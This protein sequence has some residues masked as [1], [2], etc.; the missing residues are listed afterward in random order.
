MDRLPAAARPKRAAEEFTRAQES[1]SKKP[2][3]DARNP[4]TLAADTNEED[5]ILNADVIG[6]SGLQTKRNAVNIDG[7]ESDSDNDNFNA[8]A[9]ERE[10]LSRRQK[11]GAKAVSKDEDDDDMFAEAE[12]AVQGTADGDDD[13]ELGREGKRVNK[14]VRFLEESEIEGQV[15]QS[16]SG[17]HVSANLLLNGKKR[18]GS[19]SSSSS[20]GD[21]QERDAIPE[22]LDEETALEV[23]AGGKKKHAPRL[24]AFN[25]RDEVE[26]GRFDESGTFVR[27]AADPEAFND[28]WLEGVSKKD[29][30][31]AKEAQEKRDAEQRLKDR[32]SDALLTS[33]LL[34]TLIE[35]LEVGESTLEAL[36]RLNRGRSKVK[37][38]RPWQRKKKDM[39]DVDESEE[40]SREEMERLSRASKVEE[41]TVAV[42]ALYSRGYVNI[43]EMERE[44]LMREYQ[45]QT[46]HP[47]QPELGRAKD[48]DDEEK[49]WELRYVHDEEVVHGP[50][51]T[52]TMKEWQDEGLL[53]EHAE[54]KRLDEE[55]WSRTL[56]L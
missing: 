29:I 16:K 14:D 21:D 22:E 38:V 32:A 1:A 46:G 36:K 44:L 15:L 52:A 54:Y 28:R 53:R 27:N 12:E 2:R 39:M 6:K 56:D 24:E 4:S 8:R 20:S 9:A 3:F 34:K 42:D 41:I 43:Y 5:L 7:Y 49:I 10:K 45:S 50:Y 51:S 13:E 55:E 23:G 11:N 35:R 37:K 17:G 30:K 19:V 25:L 47:F 48:A 26:E 31:A 33:D 40:M 18:A